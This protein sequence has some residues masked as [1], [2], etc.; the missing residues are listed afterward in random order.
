MSRFTLIALDVPSSMRTFL[1]LTQAPS[2][3]R[4]VLVAR[5][6]LLDSLLACWIASSKLSV[7][8]ALISVNAA[9]QVLE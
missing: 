9:S 5:P 4:S 3:P 7:E 1:S 8:V 6:I 2:T